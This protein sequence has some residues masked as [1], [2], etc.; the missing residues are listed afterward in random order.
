MHTHSKHRSSKTGCSELRISNSASEAGVVGH[1][2]PKPLDKGDVG[3]SEDH[4]E[5]DGQKGD[6][7]RTVAAIES[8]KNRTR[9]ESHRIHLP[10]H[11]LSVSQFAERECPRRGVCA[12]ARPS[13]RECEFTR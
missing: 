6:P 2:R 10:A 12:S 5:N 3:G 8:A 1:D 9:Q 7:E 11:P 4:D 13:W